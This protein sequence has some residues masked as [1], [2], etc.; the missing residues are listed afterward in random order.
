MKIKINK[1]FYFKKIPIIIFI[2]FNYNI[3]ECD[4]LNNK[5]ILDYFNNRILLYDNIWGSIYNPTTH[6]CDDTPNITADGSIINVNNASNLRWIAISQNMLNCSY[7]NKLFSNNE[8]RFKGKIKYGDTIWIE[9]KFSK[10]NGMWI[11]H[12]VKNKK[13]SNS[14]DFLQTINDNS[15]YNN[16]KLWNGRFENIKIYK[17]NKLLYPQK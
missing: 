12:D 3:S 2:L 9:S 14:V 5:K 15:L 11:V 8:N 7:R 1:I 10:I 6:Q 17:Y 16:D 13:Y 4:I